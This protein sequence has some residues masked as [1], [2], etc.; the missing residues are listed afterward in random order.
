MSQEYAARVGDVRRDA[1]AVVI[2]RSA[3]TSIAA[4]VIAA[5][6]ASSVSA[7]TATYERGVFRY[8]EQPEEN[9]EFFSLGLRGGQTGGMGAYLW[10]FTSTAVNAGPGCRAGPSE[11]FFEVVCPLDGRAPRYRLSLNRRAN[12]VDIGSAG[13]SGVIYSG[14]GDDTARDY[15]SRSTVYGGSGDADLAALRVHGGA[16]DDNIDGPDLRA[17]A[18][19]RGGTGHDIVDAWPASGWV[20]GGAGSDLLRD[21]RRPDMLVGGPGRDDIV[22]LYANDSSRDIVRVRGGGSDL[23]DCNDRPDARDVFFVDAADRIGSMCRSA[24]ILLTG[25]PR[26]L[27]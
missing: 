18:I 21:S 11:E 27:R 16:G 20:Y 25:R 12:R 9:V 13:L 23:V 2:R 24:R 7:A 5:I 19:L 1:R 22:L 26:Y 6:F 17:R 14:P 4:S 8:R 10:G 15:L 3:L